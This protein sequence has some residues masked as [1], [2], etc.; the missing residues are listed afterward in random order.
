MIT[1]K[2][3]GSLLLLTCFGGVCQTK[4]VGHLSGFFL[5]PTTFHVTNVFTEPEW[6]NQGVATSLFK[7]L[8]FELK[9][10]QVTEVTLDD[11]SDT[12][13]CYLKLGFSYVDEGCP[14]MQ[15]FLL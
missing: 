10:N 5:S 15:L 14:E 1:K 2:R 8:F 11:C 4:R 3:Q 13:Q 12:G 9:R 7:R 6:R